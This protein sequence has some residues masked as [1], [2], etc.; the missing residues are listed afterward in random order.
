VPATDPQPA[1]LQPYLSAAREYGPGFG[2]LLWASPR[3]QKIRFDA[4]VRAI[5]PTGRKVLDVGCGRADLLTF[6]VAAGS[7]PAEYV[8]VEM[9]EDLVLA[10]HGRVAASPSVT[11]RID[12]RDFV[13]DPGCMQIGADVLYFSGSLNTLSK[14]DFELAIRRAFSAAV[15]GI[16]FNFLSSTKLASAR[17]L[18]WHQTRDVVALGQSV[19]A[20]VGVIDD[21]LAGDTTVSLTRVRP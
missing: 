3:T 4:L 19:G 21:Y 2:S 7:V 1:Y 10:A 20:A 18:L 8:G 5:D 11:G 12:R 13:A 15:R 9:V 14:F 17:H 6:M 16:A